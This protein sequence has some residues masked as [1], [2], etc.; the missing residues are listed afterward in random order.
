[1]LSKVVPWVLRWTCLGCG[2]TNPESY[3]YCNGCGKGKS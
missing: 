2:C 1:M 3:N